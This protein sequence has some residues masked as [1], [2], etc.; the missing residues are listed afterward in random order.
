MICRACGLPSDDDAENCIGCGKGLLALV[1]GDVLSGRYE[2]LGG[3]GQGGMGVVYKAR[4]REL[5]ETVAIKVLRPSLALSPDMVKRFRS[6]IK[7]ARRVRHPNVCA[8]HEYGQEG[9]LRYIVMEFLEGVDLR[10]ALR[11]RGAL[12]HFEAFDIAIQVASGLQ[13]IHNLGIVHRDLKTPNLMRDLKGL[14]RLMDFG[15][16]KELTAES[17]AGSGATQ[18]GHVV[19]TPEYMSPEQAR[20]EAVDARSDIYSLGIVIFELFTGDVPFRG[21]T[22]VATLLMQLERVPPLHAAQLPGSLVPV[23]R[24]ALAKEREAR[25]DSAEEIAKALRE[26]EGERHVALS[27]SNSLWSIETMTV[28]AAASV[29]HRPR[30]SIPSPIQPG[31]SDGP[32]ERRQ[33]A[34]AQKPDHARANRRIIAAAALLALLLG[35]GAYVYL[36]GRPAA[37]TPAPPKAAA[38][39]HDRASGAPMFSGT[40]KTAVSPTTDGT[41]PGGFERFAPPMPAPPF[42]STPSGEDP[43]SAQREA[44]RSLLWRYEDALERKDLHLLK[45]VWPGLNGSKEQQIRASLRSARSLRVDLSPTSSYVEGDRAVVVCSRRDRVTGGDGQQMDNLTTATLSLRRVSGSWLI[46]GIVP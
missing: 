42:A 1:R 30:P 36:T 31:P 32:Q 43:T 5:A 45:Q 6:E 37:N 14:V 39:P 17:G 7:L 2:I 4:D 22:P 35:G 33:S 20:G 29:R 23:L 19:G 25:Y 11:R 28:P 27:A 9:A 15:V 24:R 44:I 13:A 38:S 21:D 16:A 8:I 12:S 26:A 40:V 46:D 10:Q 18:A 41:S 3:L 34:E